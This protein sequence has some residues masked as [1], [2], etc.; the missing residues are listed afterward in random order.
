MSWKGNLYLAIIALVVFFLCLF[1]RDF[2]ETSNRKATGEE[3]ERISNG[4]VEEL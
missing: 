3:W 1:I 4:Y 2:Q